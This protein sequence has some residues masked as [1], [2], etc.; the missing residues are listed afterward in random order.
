MPIPRNSCQRRRW[1]SAQ[2]FESLQEILQLGRKRRPEAESFLGAWMT[3]LQN[4]SVEKVSLHGLLFPRIDA[5]PCRRAVECIADDGMTDRGEVHAD[6]VRAARSGFRLEQ[7]EMPEAAQQTV[8]SACFSCPDTSG[9]H[10]NAPPR[11]ATHGRRDFPVKVGHS[12]V[13]QRYVRLVYVS[14]LELGRELPV[15]GVIL[16]DNYQTGRH[17]I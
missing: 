14:G 6:L 13:H 1:R 5:Q 2:G 16:G 3:Q 4:C 7:G 8:V 11:I 15:G 17:P 10:A 9:S 12:A